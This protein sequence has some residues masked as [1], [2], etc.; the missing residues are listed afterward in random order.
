[1]SEVIIYSTSSGGTLVQ[2]QTEAM[3]RLLAAKKITAKVVYLDVD[4]KDKETVWQQSGKKGVYPLLFS[5]GKFI[6]THDD[7]VNLN[8]E[9]RL[10]DVL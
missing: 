9:E 1:M 10:E 3:S 8:E 6:G 4:P 5:K 7:V 2:K